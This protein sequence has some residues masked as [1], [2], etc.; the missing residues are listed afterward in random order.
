MNFVLYTDIYIIF[1][2]KS[3]NVIS[4]LFKRLERIPIIII[5]EEKKNTILSHEVLRESSSLRRRQKQFKKKCIFLFF[6]N[7]PI[8]KLT[9]IVYIRKEKKKT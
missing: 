3:Q 9:A 2:F 6:F 4:F 8:Y 1:L 5:I 7:F